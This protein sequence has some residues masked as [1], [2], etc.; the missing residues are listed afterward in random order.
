MVIFLLIIS[1]ISVLFIPLRVKLYIS[2]YDYY[3]KLN[4]LNLLSKNGGIL[5][6]YISKPKKAK[7]KKKAKK[8]TT[9]KKPL[10]KISFKLLHR[11]LKHNFYKPK[12]KLFINLNYSLADAANTAIIY[13]LLCNINYMLYNLF[14][15]VFNFNNCD[16]NLNP[17][18][19]D[20]FLVE[21][22]I[23]SIISFNLAQIIY[24]LYLV[25]K[26]REK[27]QEVNP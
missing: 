7:V 16:I 17:E 13:G 23:S 21:F 1:F 5:K 22:T 9:K 6:K 15:I 26:S 12:F 3:I 24:I 4:R 8:T 19:K 18:Y 11:N 20:N 2:K 10:K 14:S 27:F 25:L